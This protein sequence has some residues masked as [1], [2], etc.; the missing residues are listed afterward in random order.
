MAKRLKRI[1]RSLF[2]RILLAIFVIAFLFQAGHFFEHFYQVG[3]WMSGIQDKAYMSPLG[4]WAMEALGDLFFADEPPI[5]RMGMAF[6]LLHLLGNGIFLI[7]IVAFSFFVRTKKVIA[8]FI[9]EGV[10]FLEHMALSFSYLFLNKAVGSS[11][12]WG[13]SNMLAIL[14]LDA[15]ISPLE[16]AYFIWWHFIFNAVPT[17]LVL[18]LIELFRSRRRL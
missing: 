12:F 7:G 4:T 18:V 15:G 14:G 9:F 10:H 2:V 5:R 3:I 13:R 6:Q 11:T 16:L 17:I 1:S 8:A